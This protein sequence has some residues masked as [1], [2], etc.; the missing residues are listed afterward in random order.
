MSGFYLYIHLYYTAVL[1][2]LLLYK[3]LHSSTITLMNPQDPSKD[4]APQRP[5]D[6]QTPEYARREPVSEQAAPS[7]AQTAP[8]REPEVEQRSLYHP[9]A[10]GATTAATEEQHYAEPLPPVPSAEPHPHH[11]SSVS[12]TASEFIEHD[13]DTMWFAGLAGVTLIVV[14]IIYF[15]TRDIFTAIIIMIAGILFGVAANRPP[16]NM[17]YTVDDH[18]VSIGAKTYPYADFRAFSVAQEGPLKSITFVPLKRFMPL[19][20]MYYD[21]ADEDEIAEVLSAH[22]PMQDHKADP[23]EQLMKRIRF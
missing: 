4:A 1:T 3:I 12:W 20:S 23:L 6:R 18:G 9:E 15:M 19:L 22:L 13:K 7:P 10:D 2:T 8:G 17:Q 11:T 14:A 16:R 5:H 21:P